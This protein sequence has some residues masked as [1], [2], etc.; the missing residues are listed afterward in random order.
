MNRPKVSVIVPI[1]SGSDH[2]KETIDSVLAQT[3]D[4]IEIII[5]VSGTLSD[6]GATEKIIKSYGAKIKYYKTE[7]I[8]VASALNFGIKKITGQYFSWLFP[9]D[10]YNSNKIEKQVESIGGAVNVIVIS[11]WTTLTGGGK[12]IQ[13][14]LTDPRLEQYPGCFFTFA[15]QTPLNTRAMLIPKEVSKNNGLFDG[16]LPPSLDYKMLNRLIM[17]GASFKMVNQSSLCLGSHPQQ[18]PSADLSADDYDFI[19]SDIINTLS[20]EDI[21]GYLGSKEDAVAYYKDTLTSGMPRM[22]AFLIAKIITGSMAV[23]GH[24]PT[25][26]VLLEDLSMLSETQMATDVDTLLSKI[27]KPTGK[28]KIL[29]C[30]THWLTGG[31]E[32][33]MSVLF[34]ELK[35]DYE[36]FLITPYD[37]RKSYIEV[38][39]FVTSIKIADHLFV[40]HFDSLVLSYSLLLDIDVAIGFINLFKKQ[41]N[42]YKLCVGTKIK[43]IA[44]NHEYYF[45]PYKSPT[46]YEVVEK[47]LSAYGK[48]DALVWPN[49]FNAALCGMYVENSYVIGNPNNFEVVQEGNSPKEKVIICVGRFDDYIKRVDRM[50]ECF[51]LV[52]KK[53]P[54]AKLV[55]VGKYDNDAPISQNSNTSVNNLINELAIPPSSINFVGE[56]NNVEDYYKEAKV[57][58]LTSISEGFGMVLNEAACFGVPSVCNYIPGIEDIITDGK[59]GYITGQGD[60]NSM[61]LRISNILIDDGLQKKL[62]DDAKQKVKSFDARHIGDKWRYLV[63]SL[64][65]T[66]DKDA[67]H[68]KLNRELGYKIQNQQLFTKVL[69]REL[70]EIF[71]ISIKEQG[72]YKIN[73]K[74]SLILY[75]IGRLPSRLRTNIEYEGLPKTTSKV[76]TRSYRIARNKLK[77]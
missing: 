35:N 63:N 77:V 55:L 57:L 20:Y 73:N 69:S 2:L 9:G 14:R 53:V 66:K 51:A 46:H 70:N 22:A 50:L 47:R 29:F 7:S 74:T 5:V 52:L 13:T 17:A 24:D 44:S 16:S 10:V 41:L 12:K 43:T 25:K 28:K 68:K 18:E 23:D 42:L 40:K 39:D 6:D 36:I 33:V 4:N 71:Y 75:K 56:V 31:M 60:I 15:R 3:Y 72:K 49:G 19:Y 21:V 27:A 45:Y 34:R 64:L 62:G 26:R 67:L 76:L 8:D 32:R 48:C 37:E 30:S 58:M 54:D 65:E 38:P 11:D 1:H 61:A 59:N